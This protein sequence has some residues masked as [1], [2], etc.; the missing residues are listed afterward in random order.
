MSSLAG[1]DRKRALEATI[2]W[3]L[4][5]LQDLPIQDEQ[6]EKLNF[7]SLEAMRVQ[8]RNWDLPEWLIG[9]SPFVGERQ[10]RGA[11][12]DRVE[13]PKA[14]NILPI[15]RKMLE[16]LGREFAYLPRRKEYIQDG[17]FIVG[18]EWA[19]GREVPQE[20]QAIF[21]RYYRGEHMTPEEWRAWCAQR[22]LDA[23]GDDAYEWV[24]PPAPRGGGPGP[25]EPWVSLCALY[26]I[27][28]GDP[29]ELMDLVH[30]DP[31]NAPRE[32]ITGT[33]TTK[34]I[35][36][37]LREEARR[38]AT[39]VRG[40]DVR[41]GRKTGPISEEEHEIAA[42]VSRRRGR[43]VSDEQILEELE[44]GALEGVS[45]VSIAELARLGKLRLN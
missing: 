38:S 11:E 3:C 20:R 41:T 45:S 22:G 36:R 16:E 2:R 4:R 13:L 30:P 31:E 6:L 44:D 43:G 10:A 29:E 7:G 42:Y 37:R 34:G 1:P 14:T 35:A 28:G 33:G 18:E 25:P 9:D 21:R 12:G 27:R 5:E 26:F 23:E 8:L 19:T 24:A 17:R 32:K 40:G 15:F 39:A